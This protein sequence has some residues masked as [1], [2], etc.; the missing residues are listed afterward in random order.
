M[1]V[2]VVNQLRPVLARGRRRYYT[3]RLARTHRQF[4]AALPLPEAPG[5]DDATR[6]QALT[7]LGGLVQG[8]RDLRW[9]EAYARIAGRPSASYLPD[10][11]FFA[12]L[13]PALN[14]RERT[15]ILGDKNH[16]DLLEGLPQLPTTVGHLMNGRL[17]D[18]HYRSAS[19][20]ELVRQLLP[21][22][23]L[24]V[25]P[26][27]VTGSGKGVVFVE[28][29]KLA[30][31]LPG[32]TDAIIQLPVAQHRDLAV[33][34][35]S[36]LNTLRIVTY[37]RLDGEVVHL[38]SLLRVGRVG[39]RVDNSGAGGLFCGIDAERGVLH[40]DAFTP[41][42]RTVQAH[43]DNGL[44][45]AGRK[46]PF[47]A[48]ARDAFVAAHRQTPW[49][50]IASWDAAIDTA[51]RPVMVEVNVGTSILGLQLA[52]GPV[53]EPVLDDIRQRIGSRRHSRIAGFL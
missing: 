46:V 27:R 29:S 26:S 15:A 52:A 28:A 13:M 14:P 3:W 11:I 45:F 48:A 32:R 18:P 43:P 19:A 20:A 53:F 4:V 33:L 41:G 50:D 8:Y 5:L 35:V 22:T 49:I 16:F 44:L 42:Y 6:Q 7:M 21:D 10:D 39:A 25:K 30:D 24:V 34:N 36:S 47:F 1:R 12:L 38:G 17:L 31:A 9:H 2:S 23:H 37:R 51:G 40:A